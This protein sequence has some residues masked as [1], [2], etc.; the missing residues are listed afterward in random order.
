MKADTITKEYLSDTSIFAD[1][2]NYYIYNGEQ[3]ICGEQLEECDP[4]AIALPYGADGAADVIKAVTNADL[5]YEESGGEVDMCQALQEMQME[6]EAKG[7][8]EGQT[9]GLAKGLSQGLSQGLKQGLEQGKLIQ[10]K[11]IAKN[12]Y[13]LGLDVEQIAQGVGY[14]V[15]TVKGWIIYPNGSQN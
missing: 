2:F 11:E 10:S 14:D 1:V 6:A 13:R 8:A 4:T 3:V 9:Q 12:F 15:E 7:M 5:R